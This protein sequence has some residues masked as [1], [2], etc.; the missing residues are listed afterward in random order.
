M[1]NPQKCCETD[2]NSPRTR[3]A[4]D[5][6]VA[7]LALATGA[8][9]G[10][11]GM[12][13]CDPSHGKVRRARLQDKAASAAKR[14]G[15]ELAGR[16]EDLRNR[17]KGALAKAG[18]SFGCGEGIDDGVLAAR[19]RSHMGHVTRHAHAIEVEVKEGVVALQ[20]NLP[21]AEALPL[22]AEVR[23]IP[24]VKDVRNRIATETPA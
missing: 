18:A 8:T 17:A 19:V 7:G 2:G 1:T 11:I 23:R 16:T 3:A 13:L 5:Y 9:L 6:W 15:Q 20:G 21:E 12:Y 24:G 10:A 4:S 22:I 14:T